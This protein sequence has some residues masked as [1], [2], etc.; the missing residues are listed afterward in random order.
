MDHSN[1][2]AGLPTP[3]VAD[4]DVLPDVPAAEPDPV[5]E[6][7]P[8]PEQTPA[9]EQGPAFEAPALAAIAIADLPTPN[10]PVPAVV[11]AGAALVQDQESSLI[12]GFLG[13]PGLR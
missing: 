12:K 8:V 4:L 3:Q 7:A 1:A 5:L 6:Q 13:F 10:P 2:P 11:P 9:L